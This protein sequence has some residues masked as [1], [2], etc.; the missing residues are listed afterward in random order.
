[1]GEIGVINEERMDVG[2]LFNVISPKKELMN[3]FSELKKK[4]NNGII[5]MSGISLYHRFLS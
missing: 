4:I 3:V 1:L 2:F 5:F